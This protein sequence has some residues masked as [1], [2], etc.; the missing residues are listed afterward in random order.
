MD[1]TPLKRSDKLKITLKIL[2]VL[3][4]ILYILS[5]FIDELSL[6]FFKMAVGL[7]Y[8][9]SYQLYTNYGILFPIF[10]SA[11]LLVFINKGDKRKHIL[12]YMLIIGI[13]ALHSL[14]VQSYSAQ[15]LEFLNILN[16]VLTIVAFVSSFIL[17]VPVQRI[18]DSKVPYIIFAV[19]NSLALVVSLT[20]YTII[21]F[22]F[23]PKL[24][25]NLTPQEL[26]I[27]IYY[28]LAQISRVFAHIGSALF[29]AAVTGFG[30]VHQPPLQSDTCTEDTIKMYVSDN[31][32]QD[33][34]EAAHE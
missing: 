19:A 7:D 9:L 8:Y 17:I 18:R 15:G 27:C 21:Y 22:K 6:T 3:S 25:V 11:L 2:T 20:L 16:N 24:K 26:F 32:L 5:L 4:L 33:G 31:C 12:H 30:F 10:A 23:S 1:T 34:K 29:V 14:S 28:A 13:F